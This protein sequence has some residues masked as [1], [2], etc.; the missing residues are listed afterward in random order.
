MKHAFAIHSFASQRGCS[1]P[2]RIITLRANDSFGSELKCPAYTHGCGINTHPPATEEMETSPARMIFKRSAQYVLD[3]CAHQFSISLGTRSYSRR[4]CVKALLVC[5]TAGL[6]QRLPPMV[7]CGTP[8]LPRRLSA[9]ILCVTP[10]PPRRLLPAAL[11][12]TPGIPRR[13]LPTVLCSTAGLPR[14]SFP[15]VLC[16]TPGLP[17]RLLATVPCGTPGLSRR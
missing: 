3:C 13:L 7:L 4:S 5:G 16:G 10:G 6:P 8:G 12:G 17:Q 15:T 11:C 1:F 14:R 2:G 9:I